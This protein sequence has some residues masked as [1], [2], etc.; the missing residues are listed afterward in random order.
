MKKTLLQTIVISL[1]PLT[2]YGQ[3]Y[4]SGNYFPEITLPSVSTGE[5]T[6][7]KTLTGKKLMLHLFASW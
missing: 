7:F 1:L 4:S 6:A 2:A 5:P 3:D